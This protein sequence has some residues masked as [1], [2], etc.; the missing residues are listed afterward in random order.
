MRPEAVETKEM[1]VGGHKEKALLF[2]LI[3][4]LLCTTMFQV[5]NTP[6]FDYFARLKQ[7]L[8]DNAKEKLYAGS[9]K[10]EPESESEDDYYQVKKA[11]MMMLL[12]GTTSSPLTSPKKLSDAVSLTRDETEEDESEY[13]YETEE[14]EEEEEEQIIAGGGVQ[15][16]KN[17][18][19]IPPDL[20]SYEAKAERVLEQ[21]RERVSIAPDLEYIDEEDEDVQPQVIQS[22]MQHYE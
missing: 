21:E 9:K 18:L 1:G 10:A 12:P 17:G 19:I 22:G 11:P 15:S 2:L 14:E 13:T 7:T 3:Y 4:L 6:S 8:M 5:M 16:S 20:E